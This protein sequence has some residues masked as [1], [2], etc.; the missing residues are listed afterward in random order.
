M[1]DPQAPELIQRFAPPAQVR[2]R[3]RAHPVRHPPLSDP[4]AAPRRTNRSILDTSISTGHRP[5]RHCQP[6]R[7]PTHR[8]D[9]VSRA[10]QGG[11]ERRLGLLELL[12][13]HQ[14][15]GEQFSLFIT[16]RTEAR[17]AVWAGDGRGGATRER[18][19]VKGNRTL[20]L[21]SHGTAKAAHRL[22]WSLVQMS[23]E[24]CDALLSPAARREAL[25]LASR[26]SAQQ[27]LHPRAPP[28]T[29]TD[30]FEHAHR[31]LPRSRRPRSSTSRR[32]PTCRRSSRRRAPT[33]TTSASKRVPSYSASLKLPGP[34]RASSSA[35]TAC[36]S[37]LTTALPPPSTRARASTVPAT[38]L[39]EPPNRTRTPS[40][41]PPPPRQPSLPRSPR[42]P[43]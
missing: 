41:R 10:R 24:G 31:A 20:V 14:E 37:S 36:P 8:R 34:T 22:D 39:L 26:S 9:Q 21:R 18:E 28:C 30:A 13:V 27:S 38:T 3:V 25:D 11:P 15:A 1:L 16:T 35:L 33:S 2:R 12:G 43:T 19:G 29:P 5:A 42:T 6:G 7:I 40:R 32:V 17:E 4:D 23:G